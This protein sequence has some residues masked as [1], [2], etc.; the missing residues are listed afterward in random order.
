MI[1]NDEIEKAIRHTISELDTS[2]D[3]VKELDEE[4]RSVLSIE[5]P[6][7]KH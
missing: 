3:H 2:P 4:L 7:M 1:S 6:L 5:V